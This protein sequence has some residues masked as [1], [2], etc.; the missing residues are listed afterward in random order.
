MSARERDLCRPETGPARGEAVGVC[1][2]AGQR[3]SGALAPA[4][5]AARGLGSGLRR[6]LGLGASA[7]LPRW[8]RPACPPFPAES[9]MVTTFG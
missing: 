1:V 2:H 8:A 9:T 4:E 5:D 6:R 7:R 3:C